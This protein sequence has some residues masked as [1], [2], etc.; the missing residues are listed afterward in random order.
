MLLNRESINIYGST[1]LRIYWVTPDK[2]RMF[3][4]YISHDLCAKRVPL[5]SDSPNGMLRELFRNTSYNLTTPFSQT[6]I[7]GMS[8]KSTDGTIPVSGELRVSYG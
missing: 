3:Y 2:L 1:D 6:R 8:D 7:T 5:D 4:R